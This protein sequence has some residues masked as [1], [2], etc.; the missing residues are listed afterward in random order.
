[1]GL[2]IGNGCNIHNLL[3]ADNQVVIMLGVQG[4]NYMGTKIEEEYEK[5]GLKIDYGE[6]EYLSKNPLDE[7]DI[8]GNKIKT[9]ENKYLGSA[10]QDNGSS[11]IDIEKRISKTNILVC[12]NQLYG[13]ETFYW[14]KRNQYKTTVKS[15]LAYGAET[16]TL[17]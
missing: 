10:L 1:M 8:N 16:S 4:A 12:S 7:L 9:V 6:M 15:I 3:F 17:K 2:K 5:W 14:K 11:H 13:T